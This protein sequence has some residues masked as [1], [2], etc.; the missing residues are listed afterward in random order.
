MFNSTPYEFV[1]L[2]FWLFTLPRVFSRITDIIKVALQKQD[3][4]IFMYLE[5][6]LAVRQSRKARKAALKLTWHLTIHLGFITYFMQKVAHLRKPSLSSDGYVNIIRDHRTGDSAPSMDDILAQRLHFWIKNNTLQGMDRKR[7]AFVVLP[8][9]SAAFDAVNH[10]I[11][12]GQL[13]EN[14]ALQALPRWC[15]AH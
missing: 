6:W 7:A 3:V 8:D 5:D 2:L 10:T 15:F 13:S 14:L 1:V 12:L 9:L 11:L 4:M